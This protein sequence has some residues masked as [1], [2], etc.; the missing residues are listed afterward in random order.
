[1]AKIICNS[2][3]IIGLSIIDKLNLLWEIFDE[4]YIP[5]ADDGT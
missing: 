1:M 5:E 3:P 4:V 2:S